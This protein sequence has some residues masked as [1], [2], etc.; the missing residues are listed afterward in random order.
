VT[1]RLPHDWT[2]AI[3][4]RQSGLFTARQAM[5]AGASAKQVRR[6]RET[7]L[8]TTAVGDALMLAGG[9][10]DPWTIAQGVALTWP[11]AVVGMT[12]A[13]PLHSL[14]L[15]LDPD[16]HVIVPRRVRRR[17]GI[18]THE[19]RLAPHEVVRMGLALVTTRRRTIFD[20]VG[21][22]GRDDAER[23]VAWVGSRDLLA[24]ADLAADLGARRGSWGNAQRRQAAEDLARGTLS[25]A[26][27]RLH[28]ILRRSA[29]RGW[30]FNV[31]VRSG[32]SIIARADVL[33]EAERLVVEVDGRAHHG[34]AAFQDD[35][36]RQ[37]RLVTA[38]YTVLRFTW[39]DLTERPDDV[40]AQVVTA[41]NVCR[42]RRRN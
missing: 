7:G 5:E 28:Q 17:R 24:S 23:L 33:F 40:V 19:L 10:V 15:P 6:R 25:A 29:I 22:L 11:D 39:S 38:G 16:V 36:T 42:S 35:R 12:T 32:A 1:E 20:C 9:H 31:P 13:A 41:L 30:R 2:P 8:W 26:E 37:N 34:Q 4:R 3:S 21:R 14:P 27:R 18:A